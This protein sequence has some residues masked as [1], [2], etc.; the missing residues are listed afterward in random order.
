MVFLV[1]TIGEE[2]YTLESAQVLEVVPWVTL[3]PRPGAPVYCPGMVNYRGTL[4]PVLDLCQLMHGRRCPPRLSTRIIMVH[5]PGDNAT[6]LILG[7]LAEHVTDTLT[8]HPTD[9]VPRGTTVTDA[10]YLGD[11]VRD[12]HG[13][14]QRLRLEYLVPASVRATLFTEL[15]A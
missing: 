13:M 2:R 5:Y 10:P 1:F 12:E 6:P 8:K 14:L 4:V 7:L 3:L 15:R 11:S 9:F